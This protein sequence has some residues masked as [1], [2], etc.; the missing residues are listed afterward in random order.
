LK[1]E[2]GSTFAK[3]TADKNWKLGNGLVIFQK[4]ILQILFIIGTQ[5]A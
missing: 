1:L 3:A 4:A 5:L 2:T